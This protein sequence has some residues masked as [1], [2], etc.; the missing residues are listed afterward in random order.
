MHSNEGDAVFEGPGSFKSG[1]LGIRSGGATPA[2]GSMRGTG[3]TAVG[4][5]NSVNTGQGG[6]GLG[7]LKAQAQAL[8]DYLEEELRGFEL[9][10]GI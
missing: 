2:A 4:S 10:E 5:V 3:T 6:G 7:V 9:P 1:I 8:V